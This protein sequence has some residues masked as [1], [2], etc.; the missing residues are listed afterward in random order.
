MTGLSSPCYKGAAFMAFV[1]SRPQTQPAFTG[2]PPQRTS[3][4]GLKPTEPTYPRTII[5]DGVHP[6][7]FRE[8][9]IIYCCEQCSYYDDKKQSCAMGF[10]VEKHQRAAQLR[11]YERTGKLAI[12]RSQEID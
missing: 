4:D 6:R 9:N 10:K 3:A 1:N 5:L 8:L 11:L 7:D 12:C 2:P